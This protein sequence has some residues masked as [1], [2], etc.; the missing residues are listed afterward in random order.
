MLVYKHGDL[1]K[2]KENLI[3]H[4]VNTWGVMGG[5]LALQVATQ[6]PSVNEDYK[7]FCRVFNDNCLGQYQP[8]SIGDKKYI[9]N[10]FSQKGFDTR[11]DMIDLI[12]RGILESCKKNDFTIAI[13]YKYGSGIANGNWDKIS[14]LFDNLSNEYE[15]DITIYKFE[16]K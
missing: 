3:C 5:G 9:V 10:C 6:Y 2:S 14:E 16:E 15:I 1:L 8:C 11:L 12:F 13:P 7:N 4:Q